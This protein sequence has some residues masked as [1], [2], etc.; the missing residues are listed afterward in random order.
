MQIEDRKGHGC[1]RLVGRDIVGICRALVLPAS[2]RQLRFDRGFP[3]DWNMSFRLE[4]ILCD[5][6]HVI[7]RQIPRANCLVGI[8]DGS[9]RFPSQRTPWYSVQ[10]TR[11]VTQ[12]MLNK[13]AIAIRGPQRIRTSPY[14]IWKSH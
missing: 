7:I 9:R 4:G 12:I 5:D 1:D 11:A 2:V 8:R 14:Y 3:K 6:L 13:C 10:R